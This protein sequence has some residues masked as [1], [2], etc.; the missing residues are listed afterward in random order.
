MSER[1]RR[2]AHKGGGDDPLLRALR[3]L[4]ADYEP[5]VA[6][7]SRRVERV[8][9]GHRS[10]TVPDRAG[11]RWRR[12]DRAPAHPDSGRLAGTL[13]HSRPVLLPAAAVLLVIGGVVLVNS[14]TFRESFCNSWNNNPQDSQTPCPLQPSQ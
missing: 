13:R 9:S 8:H 7:I 14:S 10:P 5:D 2:S 12:A 11:D 6:K 3:E 4:G 1:Q